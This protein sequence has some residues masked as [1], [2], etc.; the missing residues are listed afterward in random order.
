M[1]RWL[2]GALGALALLA[3]SGALLL[4]SRPAPPVIY[5]PP[6]A[7]GEA[8]IPVPPPGGTSPSS[9][10]VTPFQRPAS[11]DLQMTVKS[12]SVNMTPQQV[13]DYYAPKL[14][15]LGYSA[16]GTGQSCGPSGPC[17]SDWA[18]QRG[19]YATF[20]LTALPQ[21]AD[22]SRYSAAMELIVPP[23]RPSASIVPKDV[24]SLSIKVRAKGQDAW[25]SVTLTAPS[26]WG[27]LLK[28]VNSLPV[29]ARG[30]HGCTADFGARSEL[31][32][33]AGGKAY[34]FQENPACTSVSG[35]G[36]ASLEDDYSLWNATV[37]AAGLPN[38]FHG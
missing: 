25:T 8:A 21:G 24:Q 5:P 7:N 33:V 16:S 30:V 26:A 10:A 32:F 11:P 31:R 12:Y 28:I 22:A 37:R 1:R 6:A 15:K 36:G 18:F 17:S 3:L 20:V 2:P 35:P 4:H 34:V 23:K 14:L 13:H 38:P 27:P 19:K 9:V 29:D